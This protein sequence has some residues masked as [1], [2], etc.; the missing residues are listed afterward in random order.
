MNYPL[1][2][3]KK[4]VDPIFS[5]VFHPLKRSSF[6]YYQSEPIVREVLANIRIRSKE[7]V[8]I[9]LLRFFVQYQAY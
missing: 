1:I 2:Q 9:P 6:F 7:Q 8:S 4:D 3:V 5:T